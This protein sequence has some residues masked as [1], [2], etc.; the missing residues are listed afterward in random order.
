LDFEIIDPIYEIE[1]LKLFRKMVFNN[2]DLNEQTVFRS[3]EEHA[4]ALLNKIQRRNKE[5]K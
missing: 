3:I 2:I 1:F 4:Q 5:L